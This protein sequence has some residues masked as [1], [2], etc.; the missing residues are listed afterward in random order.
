MSTNQTGVKLILQEQVEQINAKWHFDYVHNA[1]DSLASDAPYPY[2]AW[3]FTGSDSTKEGL[4]TRIVRLVDDSI[5]S[6]ELPFAVNFFGKIDKAFMHE[7]VELLIDKGLLKVEY[8]ENNCWYEVDGLTI[9]SSPDNPPTASRLFVIV[10]QVT[11]P[12]KKQTPA[13]QHD[14]IHG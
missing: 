8:L 12:E 2:K 13:K 9:H 11:V 5:E 6:I 7:Y 14:R 10:D 3:F 1:V 4:T